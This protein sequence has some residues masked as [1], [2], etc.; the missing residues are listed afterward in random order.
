MGNVRLK[1]KR[2][3]RPRYIRYAVTTTYSYQIEQKILQ[4][5]IIINYYN[6]YF[7]YIDYIRSALIVDGDRL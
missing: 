1:L 4:T 7:Y 6:Y 3:I 5:I 2:R